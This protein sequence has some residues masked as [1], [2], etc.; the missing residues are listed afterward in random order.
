MDTVSVL[1]SRAMDRSYSTHRQSL[2]FTSFSTTPSLQPSLQ[3]TPSKP[4]TGLLNVLGPHFRNKVV[5]L[6]CLCFDSLVLQPSIRRLAHMQA[7]A[8]F[9]FY[10]NPSTKQSSAQCLQARAITG[11]GSMRERKWRLIKFSQHQKRKL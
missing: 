9:V 3:L 1:F 8:L 6:L 2:Y 5:C 4:L 7:L 10:T 11:Q